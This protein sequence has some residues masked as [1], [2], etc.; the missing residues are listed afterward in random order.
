M[1]ENQDSMQAFIEL[2]AKHD[3]SLIAYVMTLVPSYS[4]AQDILQETKVALWRSFASYESGTNFGAWA[5]KAA[6]HRVLDFRK[7][8]AREHNRL[9]FSDECYERISADFEATADFRD[10]QSERLR[11]C[12]EKLPPGHREILVRRYFNEATVEDVAA[13][14]DRTVEATYRVLSR[15]R[16]A[17]RKCLTTATQS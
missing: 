15:I 3:Q 14:V 9:W 7:R 16:L 17:L 8:K 4:D 5:R 12:I 13:W 6:L 1:S 11:A 2:L 10:Q